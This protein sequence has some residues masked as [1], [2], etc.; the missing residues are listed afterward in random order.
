MAI[1]SCWLRFAAA[2]L[3]TIPMAGQSA[4]Y[5]ITEFF[6]DTQLQEIRLAMQP[7]DWQALKDHYLDNT[8]YPCD[9]SWKGVSIANIGIRSRGTGSRSPIKPALGLDFTRYVKAQRFLDMKALVLRNFATDASLL[10]EWLAQQLFDQMG[11]PFSRVVH[12]KV[13]VNGDYAGLYLA[14]EPFDDRYSRVH[15]GEETGFLYEAQGAIDFHFGYLGADPTL[16]VPD[17][18][19][20]KTKGSDDSKLVDF[21]R[22]INQTSDAAFRQ[23]M[24]R[25]LDLGAF[26][27]HVAIDQFTGD[28]DSV[29]ADFGASNFYLYRRNVDGKWLFLT[30]DK[31]MSFSA[32]DRSIWANTDKDALMRRALAQPELK[33]RFLEA[34]WQLSNITGV[35]GEALV[36]GVDRIL[37]T[38]KQ[39][40]MDDPNRICALEDTLVRCSWVEAQ[41][42]IDFLYTV[43]KARPSAVRKEVLDAGYDPSAA[44]YP[45]YSG[46][47]VNPAS[48]EPR[49]SPGSLGSIFL[50]GIAGDEEWAGGFPLPREM[51]GASLN[52]GSGKSP[53]VLVNPSRIVFQLPAETPCGPTPIQAE[54]RGV[55]SE[56]FYVDAR[57]SA[58]GVFAVTHAD[59]SLVAEESPARPGEIL[60]AW[61]AG[62]GPAAGAVT[63]EPGP[64]NPLTLL[65]QPVTALLGGQDAPIWWAGLAPGLAGMQQIIFRV[66]DSLPNT[67]SAP[68]VFLMN[69]EPGASYNLKVP[70]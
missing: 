44:A 59:G 70:K 1:R 50:E 23:E 62:F 55:R 52:A 67:G 64:E 9:F 45:I 38:I 36:A 7:N 10:H 46:S 4:G 39:A 8:Y 48:Q 63:A 11:L 29:L 16:Y 41:A 66:P 60:V 58:P 33:Q 47:I 24:S 13:Y 22:A 61:G 21:I 68:L 19:D 57:P 35:K 20:A 15:F 5:L 28:W 49:L 2:V 32:A 17:V 54:Q 31:D 26:V 40:A 69:G 12:V 30:W 51:Q 37:P 65:S 3:S 34:L 56:T 25:Y 18:F 14:V 53:L 27:T 42:S 43:L 6:D